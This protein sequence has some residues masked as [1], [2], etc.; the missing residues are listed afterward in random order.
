LRETPAGIEVV[1]RPD[2]SAPAYGKSE[3]DMQN[4][5]IDIW[6]SSVGELPTF[7]AQSDFDQAECEDLRI[8][9]PNPRREC[10]EKQSREV[11]FPAS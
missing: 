1:G 11:N 3:L 6:L 5:H 10:E 2:G 4:A 7:G 8:S 9:L